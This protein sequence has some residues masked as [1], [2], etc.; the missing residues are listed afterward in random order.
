MSHSKTLSYTLSSLPFPSPS[1]PL[2]TP[3]FFPFTLPS[4]CTIHHH[5]RLSLSYFL[6]PFL[7]FHFLLYIYRPFPSFP[8]ILSYR[9]PSF[10][11]PLSSLS[12]SSSSSQLPPCILYSY[13]K[14]STFIDLP[15]SPSS[16]VFVLFP[17]HLLVPNRLI[18]LYPYLFFFNLFSNTFPL[19]SSNFTF[20]I[21]ISPL[22][23]LP[24]LTLNSSAFISI[25]IFLHIFINQIIISN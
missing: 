12:T 2:S 14:Y 4:Y 19:F 6:S 8:S 13:F 25:P 16:S 11:S 1:F 23:Y 10:P 7:I 22:S 21:T 3:L 20:T 17:F 5:L 9:I 15:F 24:I 18:L